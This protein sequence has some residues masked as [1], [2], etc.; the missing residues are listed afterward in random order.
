MSLAQSS[1]TPRRRLIPFSSYWRDGRIS[2]STAFAWRNA[3]LLRTF[4]VGG[5]VFVDADFDTFIRENAE[6]RGGR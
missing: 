1:R 3:G 2:K 5:K 6:T 4:R